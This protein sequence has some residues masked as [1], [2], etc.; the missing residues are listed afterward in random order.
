MRWLL[1]SEVEW[2]SAVGLALLLAL[3]AAVVAAA[4]QAPVE[5]VELRLE[6]LAVS[7]GSLSRLS[8][9]GRALLIR[10]GSTPGDAAARLHLD[11]PATAPGESRW[12]VWAGR[13]AVD[14]IVLEANGWRSRSRDFYAPSRSAGLLPTGFLFPLP[15]DHAGATTLDL[16]ASSGQRGALRIRVL[17]ETAA[18]RL[19]QRGAVLAAVVYAAMFTLAVVMLALY[20]AARDRT[21]LLFLG[22]NMLALLLMAADNGHLYQVPVLQLLSVWRG[23]GTWALGL[24]FL[25][26]MLQLLQRY[27]WADATLPRF[28]RFVDAYCLSLGLLAAVCL[29]GLDKINDWIPA[30]GAAL[31][32]VAGAS[33]AALLALPGRRRERPVRAL[34]LA[35][36]L[37]AATLLGLGTLFPGRWVDAAWLRHAYQ[38]A[39]VG[40]VAVLAMGLIGRIGKFRSERDQDRL[41]RVDSEK[42][43]RREAARAD[44][45]AALQAKLR[46]LGSGDVEWAAFR[47]LLEHLLPQV[48][49]EFAVV[50]ASGYQGRDMLVVLPPSRQKE[51]EALV[52]RRQLQ[53][54][55]HAANGIPLQQPVTVA[56]QAEM[57]AIEALV[58]LPVRAP[59]WGLLLLQRSGD[60]GFTSEELALAGEFSRLTLLHLEQALAAINLRR[61]AELDA[62]TG[63]FNRRTIDQ[64]MARCFVDAS[65][66]GHPVSVL[67]VDIDHFKRINDQYGHACGDECLRRVSAALHGTLSGSDLLGRYGGEEFIVVLPGRGGAEAREIGERLRAAI[68]ALQIEWEGEL[69]RLTVSVGM[70]TRV[71]GE[72][73]PAATVDRADKALYAAKHGG[74]NCVQVAPAIFG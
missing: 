8:A 24:L 16:H 57:V 15:D 66:D 53:L 40:A 52:V 38:L 32:T 2:I 70:A 13:A 65:R 26:A 29:L 60:E 56:E 30:A 27:S 68:E 7:D 12:V 28:T 69:L 74:R 46:A 1:T 72:D 20:V 39:F 4:V 3:F 48:P 10:G 31:W 9:D 14:R 5:E 18:M 67:F 44:L 51:A 59:A 19:E 36:L 33:A 71:T 61:S 49:V 23:Q 43:M 63:T 41:A 6:P 58:P 22:T 55:R 42:R 37:V 35:L 50:M 54:K 62:L 21:Y 34:A 47:L 64:W 25:A 11:L 17:R 73:K 45:N